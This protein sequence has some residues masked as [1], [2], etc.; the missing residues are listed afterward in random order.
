MRLIHKLLLLALTP[1]AFAA[2]GLVVVGLVVGRQAFYAES[3]LLARQQLE[4]HSAAIHAYFAAHLQ[5]LTA[6][7]Q[8]ELLRSAPLDVICRQLPQW[9]R[10]LP[11]ANG[12]SYI[13]SA[14]MVHHAGVHEFAVGDRDYFARAMRGES[15]ISQALVGRP[16]PDLLVVAA[17]PVRDAAGRVQGALSAAILLTR[18]QRRIEAIRL[19]RSGYA[20]LMDSAGTMIAGAPS[21]GRDAL[22]QSLPKLRG[23]C[24][25][26]IALR[27]GGED[28]RVY[29]A[30]V[31]GTDWTLAV[32]YKDAEI[33]SN[34]HRSEAW[35]LALMLAALLLAGL[36]AFA[37]RRFIAAPVRQLAEA[38][39]RAASGDLGVR[40]N[41]ST[42]DE[43]AEL[44][45]SFNT[46]T[47]ALQSAHEQI[48]EDEAVLRTQFE[49]SNIGLALTSPAMRWL[50]VNRRLTELLGYREEE[51]TQRT[52][53]DITHP[54][55]LAASTAAFR[56]M[57][58]GEVDAYEIEKRFI[59]K[60]GSVLA[61]HLTL[62]CDR[63][64][65]GAVR[66]V[67]VSLQDVTERQRAELA[68]RESEQRFRSLVETS[69]GWFWELDK[70]A[71]FVYVSPRV[72]ASLGYSPDELIGR[73]TFDLMPEPQRASIRARY[74]EFA[75]GGQSYFQI[76][77]PR[78]HRDGHLVVCETNA[79]PIFGLSGELLGY[80]GSTRDI[81]DRKRSEAALAESEAK[82]RTIF[83]NA[84][85]GIAI[86]D[87]NGRFVEVNER[88]TEAMGLSRE[89]LTGAPMTTD[90]RIFHVNDPTLV[91]DVAAQ[92]FG[93]GQAIQREVELVRPADGARR[94]A[95][96]SIRAITLGGKPHALA[97][98]TDVT[99]RIHLEEQLRQAQKMEAIGQLAGGVAHD[100]NNLL[101]VINGY[102][103]LLAQEV[104]NNQHLTV[105][106]EQ[107]RKAGQRAAAL[108]QQLLAFSR[109]QVIQPKPIN[110]NEI[111][112]E[113]LGMLRRSMGD[114]ILIDS[115]LAPELGA[116]LADPAQLH[117][118][119]V[120]LAIN[121]RDAM[122]LG[123]RLVF[124]T[125]NIE[126]DPPF[127]GK[128]AGVAPGSYV[129][130]SV[131]DSGVGMDS[132]TRER[133]FEP[134]F[135][136]KGKGQ[137]TGLGLATVHGIVRQSGGWIWVYS[138]L[139]RG[140]TF[141]IFLPRIAGSAA[142]APPDAGL[143][144]SDLRGSETLLLVEDQEAVR[145][146]STLVLSSYGYHVLDAS[147]GAAA[148]ALAAA[149]PG[150]IELLVTDVEM[151]GM[152]GREVAE[153]L[154]ALRPSIKVLYSSGYT[155]D[156]VVRRGVLRPGVSY[157][158]KPFS[159]RDL[160]AK[161]RELLS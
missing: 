4:Q 57:V 138:E 104:E 13:D 118:V 15:L 1:L 110:L 105:Q 121:A 2:A 123:G 18:L 56:S 108:T 75:S 63:A 116:V 37:V 93:A 68:L 84:P 22:R 10:A 73:T 67:M 152:S 128:H 66:F 20:V 33:L 82:F 119:L 114:D 58:A 103:E 126:L 150:P 86:S 124:E 94:R 158:A 61:A 49:R 48:L 24:L 11:E 38:Q 117:Q 45:A 59:R 97:M 79:V 76:E 91:R 96:L 89:E 52:W 132:A 160:A 131:T 78:I 12:L 115:W 148:L 95:L 23:A 50:R 26:P 135:T 109:K 87:S 28:C 47:A 151:P 25:K 137:G 35:T 27:L 65:D 157:L 41:V 147:D 113:V 106:V 60:D 77:A 5:T 40:A 29:A 149:H 31:P 156:V 46:M 69:E 100:F 112:V 19:G 155:E 143:A 142:L 146:F 44:A 53:A 134:F 127:V 36:V 62:S 92:V 51:L 136:T 43:F 42:G 161:I 120:N 14:G 80:R 39:A 7:A 3:D 6:L 107:I 8:S 99:E 154:T 101:T 21:P 81:T 32:V 90:P 133:I 145:R 70:E 85:Y 130:L 139:G 34:A 64:P 111:I 72:Q 129:Q 30:P 71:R 102:G 9:Q 141:K 144:G 17:V 140:T 122:P 153:R 159:P 83:E 125:A 88:V 54:G 55:D 98:S 74:W 16:I